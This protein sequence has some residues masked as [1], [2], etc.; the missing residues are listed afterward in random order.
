LGRTHEAFGSAAISL[1]MSALKGRVTPFD[2]GGLVEHIVPVS[3]WSEDAQR[4]YLAH[5]SWPTE[6]LPTL[7]TLYPSAARPRR[8]AYL[9]CERPDEAGPH[10]VWPPND[11]SFVASIWNEPNEWRSWLWEGRS[12]GQLPVDDALVAWSCSS[13]TYGSIL[14]HTEQ[15]SAAS[16]LAWVE[17]LMAKF[18]PGGVSALI[19]DLRD[20]QEAA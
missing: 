18:V 3:E 9:N 16:E 4:S 2:S 1:Q 14:E 8:R 19:Q 15:M 20:A 13:T 11:D 6:D 5:F 17:S 7:L 10:A 12:E